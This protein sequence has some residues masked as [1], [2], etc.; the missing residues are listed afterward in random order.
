MNTFRFCII[1]HASFETPGYITEWVEKKGHKQ[2][3]IKTFE[4]QAFPELSNFDVLIIM[5]G[6]M[7]VYDEIDF[8]WLIEEKKFIQ[9][10]IKHHKKILGVCLGSQLI[11]SA[12]GAKVYRNKEKEIG[13]FPISKVDA[14]NKFIR[15][16]PDETVVFHWHGDTFDLPQNAILLASSQACKNQ[17][18]T[19]GDNII[20]LQFHIEVTPELV[21]GLIENGKHEIIKSPFIQTITE[22][23]N[24][25]KYIPTLHILLDEILEKLIE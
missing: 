4:N 2:L 19:V 5:G 11:A 15:L 17:A 16:F 12:L 6:P 23:K 25:E 8:P 14:E 9:S 18:F 10:C 1:Q 22:I 3:I 13:Y 20:A 21:K 7:G 24:G